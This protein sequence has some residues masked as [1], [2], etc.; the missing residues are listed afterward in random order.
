[1]TSSVNGLRLVNVEEMDLTTVQFVDVATENKKLIKDFVL[2]TNKKG[3]QTP[4]FSLLVDNMFGIIEIN[5]I[6]IVVKIIIRFENW[7]NIN[8]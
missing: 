3:G 8:V 4:P 2:C 6:T 5:D 7:I 1:M